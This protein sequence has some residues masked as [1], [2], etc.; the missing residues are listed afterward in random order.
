MQQEEH[1]T[2]IT[3]SDEPPIQQ[4]IANTLI[5]SNHLPNAVA[6]LSII[7]TPT[8]DVIILPMT[9]AGQF[10]QNATCPIPCF[11]KENCQTCIEAQCM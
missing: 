5:A 1:I 11:L 4:V 8:Q 7:Q 9:S 10:Q 3:S 6:P 2:T